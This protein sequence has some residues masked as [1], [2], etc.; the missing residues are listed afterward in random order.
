[1]AVE[2]IVETGSG[3]ANANSYVSVAN[4][5]VYAEARGVDFPA[6]NDEA[7][8]MLIRASDYLEAQECLY[9]G[10]R[11]SSAQSLAWPRVGVVLNCDEVP[12]NV[13][14]KSLI[15][16]QVQLAMAINA[17]FDLQPN[18]SPQDYVTREKVG[19]IET[20][21]ADPTKVGIMP[22]FTAANALLA[23]LFGECAANKFALRT[24]R[25]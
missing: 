6:D 7:A 4:A 14:P 12:P 1:M 25:V 22:T 9:Q 2:I 24:I 18:V 21:Y 3:V 23:P 20:E 17:G 15:A 5:R 13:I 19:P 8:T 11:T 16:A 10:K